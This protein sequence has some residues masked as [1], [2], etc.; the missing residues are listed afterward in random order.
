MNIL[1]LANKVPW[2]LK[3]GGAI[4]T[5]NLAYGLHLNGCN[6]SI[7][8]MNTSKHPVDAEDIPTEIREKLKIDIVN[9]NTDLRFSSLIKNLIFSRKPYIAERFESDKF[10]EKLKHYLQTKKIDIVILEILYMG[11][12]IPVIREYSNAHISFHAPNIEHE[13]WQHIAKHEKNPFKKLYLNILSRRISR[14]E[15]DLINSYDS[16]VPVSEI[17]AATYRQKGVNVPVFVANI[18]VFFDKTD[19]YIQN[20]NKAN[21]NLS[22]AYIGA[23]DWIP[24]LEGLVWFLKRVWPDVHKN[25]PGIKFYIAGRNAP[26]KI[27]EICNKPGIEYLG[28]VTDAYKFILSKSIMVVPLLSGSGMRVKIIESLALKKAIV[29]T[30]VGVEGINLFNNKH[31]RIEDDPKAFARACVELCKD[32]NKRISLGE[33]GS[34][35]VREHYDNLKICKSLKSFYQDILK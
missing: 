5:F 33:A 17:N 14:M 3:D 20:H 8:A 24:N 12:Y 34:Q 18:G 31:I 13:I 26:E 27:R 32:K 16:L 7:L 9:I 35:M 6:V 11:T 29:S 23:L 22:F 21:E 4:G 25:C 2:P 15:S 19:R 30:S 28:E 10:K 1:F